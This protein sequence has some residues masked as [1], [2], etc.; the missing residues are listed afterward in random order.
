MPGDKDA[1]PPNERKPDNLGSPEEN[2][3][4]LDEMDGGNPKVAKFRGTGSLAADES[5]DRVQ[6]T[7]LAQQVLAESRREPQP[8]KAARK[9]TPVLPGFADICDIVQT[10]SVET[11]GLEPSTPGLQSPCSPN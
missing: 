2:S 10:C 1:M 6:V 8:S 7:L 4:D 3:G 9:E 5:S 11:K